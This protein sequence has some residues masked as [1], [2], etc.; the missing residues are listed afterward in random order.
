M[1]NDA[2]LSQ[3]SSEMANQRRFA[4]D[5]QDRPR[6][7]WTVAGEV[8]SGTLDKYAIDLEQAE[9]Y[10]E[11]IGRQLWTGTAFVEPSITRSAYDEDDWA[12]VT[13]VVDVGETQRGEHLDVASY[14]IDGRS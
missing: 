5:D 9:V 14:C 2:E 13:I 6:Y 3:Y 7:A 12:T 8:F 11:E 4:A 10:G 1:A